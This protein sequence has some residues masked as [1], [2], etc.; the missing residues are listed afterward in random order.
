MSRHIANLL[1]V[2]DR[3]PEPEV[4]P[5]PAVKVLMLF[6]VTLGIT[7]IASNLAALK[8]WGLR[9]IFPQ[10]LLP[11]K[12]WEV[13]TILP[14]DAGIL[15]F[16]LSYVI[17]DLLINTFGKKLANLVA[18]YSSLMA[19][20]MAGIL[21]LAKTVLAGFSGGNNSAFEIL[22][23]AVGRIFL[24]SVI[25]FLAS[26]IVNNSC[27]ATMRNIQKDESDTRAIRRR[28]IFSSVPAHLLDSFLFEVLAFWGKV[29]ATEFMKQIIFAFVIGL[30]IEILVSWKLTPW[31]AIKLKT[32]LRYSDGK[33]VR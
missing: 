24:A 11:L 5:V 12:D 29:S 15:L 32:Y 8:I 23:H 17:G 19:I 21:W 33:R 18:I 13:V 1:G 4:L 22:Q 9:I 31:L 30:I 10:K 2:G 7:L 3:T 16:P 14:V 20:V 26:Q 27:F 25:G 28:A 6:A